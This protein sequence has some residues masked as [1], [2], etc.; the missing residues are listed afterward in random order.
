[1]PNKSRWIHCA[2]CGRNKLHQAHELCRQCYYQDRR[3]ETLTRNRAYY[4]EHRE[5]LLREKHHYYQENAE[6]IKAKVRQWVER[7]PKRRRANSRRYYRRH[8]AAHRKRCDRWKKENPDKVREYTRRRLARLA[9]TELGP[10]DEV[11]I[12]ERDGHV[13]IY[14]G[15]AGPLTLDHVVALSNGGAHSEENLVAACLSCNSSKQ[16][17]M[18]EDWLQTQPYSIAW[19]F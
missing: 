1:M 8:R 4:Q 17:A 18:L 7:N 2:E 19:L 13:C 11:A 5:E 12:Y 14:C 15:L 6:D 10:V 9:G 16:A 3:E